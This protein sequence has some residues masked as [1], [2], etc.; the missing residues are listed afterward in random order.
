MSSNNFHVVAFNDKDISTAWSEWD[1]PVPINLADDGRKYEARR[2]KLETLIYWTRSLNLFS[3][4][5]L[6]AE[7]AAAAAEVKR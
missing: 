3:L 5:L 1:N 4:V 7:P 2:I 6:V